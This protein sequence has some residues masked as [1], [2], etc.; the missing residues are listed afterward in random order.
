ML[1]S[2]ERISKFDD[3]CCWKYGSAPLARQDLERCSLVTN[4]EDIFHMPCETQMAFIC[5]G[6]S[7]TFICNTN[8][9]PKWN[10]NENQ[11]N[12]NYQ[13]VHIKTMILVKNSI[14]K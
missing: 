4:Q 13:C 11:S 1:N 8:I 12:S 10:V 5:K 3:I 7:M 2:D 9:A 6:I 14:Y